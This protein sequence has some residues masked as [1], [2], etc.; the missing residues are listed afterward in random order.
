M[1]SLYNSNEHINIYCTLQLSYFLAHYKKLYLLGT[2][3]IT[4]IHALFININVN[5]DSVKI[6]QGQKECI[7]I[8]IGRYCVFLIE[9]AL[10]CVGIY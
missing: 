1:R 10:K 5:K 6:I 3:S 7:I 2:I 4:D 9:L 8:N